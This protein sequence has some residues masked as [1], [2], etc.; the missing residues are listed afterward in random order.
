VGVIGMDG[1]PVSGGIHGVGAE[2]AGGDSRHRALRC[3]EVVRCQYCE[4]E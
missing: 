1:R 2:L 4:G 3:V